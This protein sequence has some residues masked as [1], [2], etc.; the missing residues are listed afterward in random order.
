M[1][2]SVCT[3]GDFYRFPQ[4][5]QEY[6]FYNQTKYISV[7]IKNELEKNNPAHFSSFPHK[8]NNLRNN[9]KFWTEMPRYRPFC[10]KVF[11]FRKKK[12]FFFSWKQGGKKVFDRSPCNNK[13][14]SRRHTFIGKWEGKVF[15][16]LI[17][18]QL[19][20]SSFS[21][22]KEIGFACSIKRHACMQA[23]SQ[24]KAPGFGKLSARKYADKMWFPF[25][26]I[27][28]S[29]FKLCGCLPKAVLYL[30]KR[31]FEDHVIFWLE[32]YF[33]GEKCVF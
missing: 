12:R 23:T 15:H 1:Q 19:A 3:F 26:F 4:W 7:A 24:K 28:W 31:G 18:S 6:I 2:Q 30:G 11:P 8:M 20:S 16:L 13:F 10:T 9:S 27:S 21:T 25:K 22:E 32:L 17:F 14:S 5:T 29:V 33:S